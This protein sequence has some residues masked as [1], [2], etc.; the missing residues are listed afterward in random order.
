MKSR[1]AQFA[2]SVIC[3][4]LG[5]IV[6]M[7]FRNVN[8]IQKLDDSNVARADQLQVALTAEREKSE[9]LYNQIIQY[10]EEL[11]QFRNE[12]SD[13]GGYAQILEDKLTKTEIY[14]GLTDVHGPGVTITMRDSSAP[15]NTGINSSYFV[16]HDE[17]MLKVINELRDAQAEAIAINGE[18]IISTSEIK[19]S[20]A[21]IKVNDVKYAEPYVI[22]AIGNAQTLERALLAKD[23]LVSV[24]AQWGIEV[25]IKKEQDITIGAYTGVKEFQYA[26]PVRN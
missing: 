8:R 14:A 21:T 26:S 11:Q 23:G 1:S 10:S 15:N 17:D 16:I 24:L 7:Q 2:I 9:A 19:C 12:A 4:I 6:A 20:G 25:E 22:T 18:R 5:C 3:M 13:A